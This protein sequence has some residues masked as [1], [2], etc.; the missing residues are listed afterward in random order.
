MYEANGSLR[1]VG[2][3]GTGFSEK[4]LKRL[5][6]LLAPLRREG[7][8]FGAGER[9]PR[10]AVFVEPQLVAEVEFAEWTSA[11]NI[12]HPSYKG[13][14][15]DKPPELVV[16]EDT[17]GAAASA[18]A[19]AEGP[20]ELRDSEATTLTIVSKSPKSE[21]ALV[22][23]RELKTLEPRARSSTRRPVSRRDS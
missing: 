3:V 10:E 13:L 8:P 7:S 11:G 14:R 19:A 15:E 5:Q 4:E 16:R 6:G 17:T 1:Y 9:P 21:T 23:G 2:R 12:R 20:A 18:R 22:G